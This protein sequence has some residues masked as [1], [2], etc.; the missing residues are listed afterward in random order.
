MPAPANLVHE[1][2]TTT[3]TGNLTLS[4]P[5][6][7]Q[8]FND[9]FGTGGT[10]VF[11]YFISHQSAAEWERGTGHLSDATTLV[12]DTVI[13]STNAD[14]AVNF[15]A[16]TKD[17]TNDVPAA[18]QLRTEGGQTLTGTLTFPN[19]GLHLL[20]T[21]ASHDLI[22]APGSDLS[23]D[24]TLTVT[25]GDANRTLT[26]GADSSIS[27]T[28]YVSGG[29]DVA[30]A[31]GGTGA[32]TAANAFTALKQTATESAT[33]VVEW[34]TTAEVR[35]A[36]ASSDQVIRARSLNEA[37]ALVTL[38]DA[39]TVAVDWTSGINFTLTLTTNRILGNPTNEI[40]GTWRTV[41]VVSDGGP[42]TLT[43]GTEYGGTPP[44]LTDITT[45]QAY[46]L[47]IYCRAAGQFLVFSADGSPA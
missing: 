28:A 1:L 8:S 5:N 30:V 17:V 13:E 37:S 35:A 41:Y 11:D 29:T 44:T 7:K 25:T 45:T 34:A 16:G 31:D 38:T 3:G 27:G 32:S 20:D 39:A 12:R 23:A 42:D 24:R 6:G 9:A 33:G 19:T 18:N 14:A 43:F 22:I 15:S 36:S 47:N 21:N 4:T 46:L 40:P 10:D 2:S 26:I